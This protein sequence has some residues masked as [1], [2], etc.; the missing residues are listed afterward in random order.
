MSVDPSSPSLSTAEGSSS[1]TA[2]AAVADTH[3]AELAALHTKNFL[4][5]RS[6]R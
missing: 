4:P 3:S 1:D 2:T 5:S 6:C